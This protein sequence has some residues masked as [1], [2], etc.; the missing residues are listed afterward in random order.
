MVVIVNAAIVVD[1]F[2]VIGG[3]LVS[4]TLL[5][6][7]EKSKGKL[8]VPLLYIH[9]YLRITPLYIVIICVGTF[10]FPLL[11]N[12]PY[13]HVAKV[14]AG[15]CEK[16]WWKN[17]LYINNLPIYNTLEDPADGPVSFTTFFA[18]YLLTFFQI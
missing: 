6:M 7:L 9:R 5:V 1:V 11:G 12:G 18:K 17:I 15:F 13:W 8:N 14:W 4:L 2:F 3:F 10:V 16:N